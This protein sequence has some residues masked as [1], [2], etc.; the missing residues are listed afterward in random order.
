MIDRAA[1]PEDAVQVLGRA[2]APLHVI[3]AVEHHQPV[4]QQIDRRMKTLELRGGLGPLA[5]V[6]AHVAADPIERM[7]PAAEAVGQLALP[8][9]GRPVVESPEVDR[10]IDHQADQPDDQYP[11][12][13]RRSLQQ[14]ERRRGH[15]DGGHDEQVTDE[16]Q[17]R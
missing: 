12:R 5:R 2:V 13:R 6:L 8:G 4:G 3:E 16:D 14:P 10:V 9:K 7:P 17:R 1:R 15:Q 11:D